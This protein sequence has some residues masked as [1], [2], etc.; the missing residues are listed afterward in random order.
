MRP[1][2][3]CYCRTT[4]MLALFMTGHLQECVGANDKED[5]SYQPYFVKK[6]TTH[7]ILDRELG[8]LYKRGA[9]QTVT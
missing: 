5:V 7:C 6:G 2:I 4:A 9:T 1:A 3:Q 8:P